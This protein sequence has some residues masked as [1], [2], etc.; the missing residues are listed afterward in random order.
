M[1]K[2]LEKGELLD[3]LYVIFNDKLI[4]KNDITLTKNAM[5]FKAEYATG[6]MAMM[7]LDIKRK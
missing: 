6:T 1:H 4:N 2:R 7:I 5:G 3:K